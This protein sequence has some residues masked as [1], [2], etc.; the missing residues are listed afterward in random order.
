MW[1]SIQAVLKV[2]YAPAHFWKR[3]THC[4]VGRFLFWSGW[5]QSAVFFLA[6]RVIR[7]LSCKTE[8]GLR[9]IIFRSEVQATHTYCG[10]PLFLRSYT[11]LKRSY[12]RGRL[13]AIGCQG[14][15]VVRERRGA[16]SLTA[17]NFAER[18][19]I[20]GR[21]DLHF[22]DIVCIA[23]KLFFIYYKCGMPI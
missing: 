18:R 7:E 4:F 3:G 21:E 9:N 2:F 20:W 23:N 1:H 5:W 15:T 16:K 22:L 12:H 17:R 8:G 13:E 14:R 6:E 19:A 10:R 11:G